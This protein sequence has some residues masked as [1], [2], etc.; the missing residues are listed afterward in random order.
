MGKPRGHTFSSNPDARC[1]P[2]LYPMNERHRVGAEP[3][4]GKRDRSM[5]PSMPSTVHKCLRN[6]CGSSLARSFFPACSPG[7][8]MQM[9][10]AAV[11]RSVRRFDLLVSGQAKARRFRRR[12]GYTT[13]TAF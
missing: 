2:P 1:N 11:E 7:D 8:G 9:E 13:A 3:F 12:A 5:M 4:V 6:R 10:R